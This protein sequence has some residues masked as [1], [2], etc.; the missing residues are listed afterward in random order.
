MRERAVRRAR[1][2]FES[3]ACTGRDDRAL[4]SN[5]NLNFPLNLKK[6]KVFSVSLC[7]CHFTDGFNWLCFTSDLELWRV[8]IGAF[9]Y[10]LIESIGALPAERSEGQ[11]SY[12]ATL[13]S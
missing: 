13:V 8:A 1:Q 6:I 3:W 11:T 5:A 10:C 9:Y 2:G 7:V 12:P 4:S